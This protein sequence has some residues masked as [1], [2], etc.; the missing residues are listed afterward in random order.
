MRMKLV[1]ILGSPT[2]DF[3]PSIFEISK[4]VL[5]QT[6]VPK[7]RIERLDECIFIRFSWR[8]EVMSDPDRLDPRPER[9]RLK[10]RTIVRSQSLRKYPTAP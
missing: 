3:L 8:D 4:H 9:V 10:F 5:I 1:V 7:S 6:L 2:L